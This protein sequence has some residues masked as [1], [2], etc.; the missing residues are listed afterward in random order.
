MGEC[1][2]S[3]VEM[4][5]AIS[6]VPQ[7]KSEQTWETKQVKAPLFSFCVV[8]LIYPKYGVIGTKCDVDIGSHIN[9]A[10]D[11]KPVT[12]TMCCLCQRS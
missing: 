12:S 6:L 4:M 11:G 9:R 7:P 10:M 5:R 3:M 2:W 1:P 8:F